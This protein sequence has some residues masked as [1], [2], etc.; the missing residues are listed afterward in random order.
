M[1]TVA[2]LVEVEHLTKL[3]EY[4]PD[5]LFIC[6]ASFEDRCLSS[7]SGM[8]TDFRTRFAVI[9]FIEESLYKKQVETNLFKL[10]SELGKRTTEGIFVIRCQRDG[11]IEGIAQ[12]RNIWGQCKPRDR[13]EPFITID[14]SGFTKIYLFELLHYFMVE[15]NLGLSRLLHTTQRYLPTKLTRGVQQIT[16]INNFF[17]SISYE[18]ETV[19]VLLL[20]FEPDRSLA[21]WK[22]FNP[23][24]TIALITNP[25]RY[26]NLDYLKYARENNSFLLSQPSV[27]VIDVPAD[28]PYVVKSVL[29]AI[30]NDTRGLFN[31]VI[32]PFGTK[33][34]VIGVFLFCLDYPKVQ[35]VYSFPVKYTRSYLKRKPGPTLLLPLAPVMDS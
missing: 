29:E 34:Q 3:N 24:K 14:I 13:D 11:P 17:G 30:H 27:E 1:K 23:A 26:G 22:H 12:L 25:P 16:T 10:Q 4:G 8:G 15:L 32:G 21:V 35:V 9:F 31:M 19:L 7:V 5:D 28:S 33:P 18:K 6:C 2:E 20:G